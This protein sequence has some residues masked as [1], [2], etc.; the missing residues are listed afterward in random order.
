M[1]QPI[2]KSVK[3]KNNIDDTKYYITLLLDMNN[4]MK[5]CLVDKRMNSNGEEYGMVLSSLRMIGRVLQMRDFKYCVA[6]YD[7]YNSGVLRYNIYED[8]K[9]NRGKHYEIAAGTTEYDRKISEFCKRTLEYYG[10]KNKKET[11]RDE[12]DDESFQRQRAILQDILDNLYV[13]Q[14]IYDEV[15]GDDLIAYYVQHRKE[16]EKIVIVSG[17]MD[18]TQ[19]ISDDVCVYVPMQKKSITKENSVKEL[20]MTHENMVLKKILC[21][22]ASDNIKGIKGM[23]E[24]TLVKMFPEII[25]EKTSLEAILDH[26]RRI[27]DERKA[28]KKKP[29]KVLENVL[30]GVTEGVQGKDIY[31]V[32]KSIIDLSEPMLTD[33]AREGI[34][35][36]SY[37]PIDPEGR[38]I[39]NVYKIIE[40]NGMDD[41]S[42]ER[43]FGNLFGM[44]ERIIK[45]EK[46]NAKENEN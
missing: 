43:V 40:E 8:Y 44:Y 14:F 7:G 34:E 36:E 26:S 3:E 21:G 39:A 22:D 24:Q 16:N 29:L 27:L 17:D 38:D 4:I 25:S 35:K 20:G 18:L 46:E 28:N 31:K 10:R 37:A 6:C 2:R 9:A 19:L 45:S 15:E 13:R 12:T 11:V 23:G 5:T 41:I 33:E 32:N 1:K 42:N 30:N